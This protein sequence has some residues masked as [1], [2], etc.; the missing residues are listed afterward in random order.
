MNLPVK[1]Y[2]SPSLSRRNSGGASRI[3]TGDVKVNSARQE[4]ANQTMLDDFSKLSLKTR[5][6]V[7]TKSAGP[8]D[9][10][11]ADDAST[12]GFDED[13]T[14]E[15]KTYWV[16]KSMYAGGA[17]TVLFPLKKFTQTTASSE[18]MEIFEN[19]HGER[20][21]TIVIRKRTVRKKSRI[22]YFKFGP[23]AVE[24]NAV[25]GAFRRAGFTPLKPHD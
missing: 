2:T 3:R 21:N 19:A 11:F 4:R 1:P 18:L 22:L 14:E 12:A 8:I 17:D 25:R 6:I 9:D 15:G 16:I 23:R 5:P 13:E 24:F 7:S 10:D 20:D